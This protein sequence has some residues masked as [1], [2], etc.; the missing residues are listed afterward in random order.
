MKVIGFNYTKLSA[1]KT[2]SDFK[3]LK[4]ESAMNIDNIEE[5]IN[6][7]VKSE[8]IFLKISFS[9]V[10]TYKPEIA[11][12]EVRG[13]IILALDKK[14]GEETLKDWKNKKLDSKLRIAIFNAILRKSNVKTLEMEEMIN[15]PYHFQLPSL[16]VE[17]KK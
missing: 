8:E 4:I 5:I 6:K 11:K 14:L 3:G 1:E 12:I 16:K 15:V 7:Q 9:N 2:K 17:S 10:L 13:E